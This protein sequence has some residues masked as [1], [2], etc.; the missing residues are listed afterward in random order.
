MWRSCEHL[1]ARAGQDVEAAGELVGRCRQRRQQPNHVLARARLEQQQAARA[2]QVHDLLRALGIGRRVVGPHD[3][4]RHH[5]AKAAHVADLRVRRR[6]ARCRASAVCAAWRVR[7]VEH[8]LVVEHV[9]HGERRRAGHGIAGVGAA[10]AAGRRRV[11]DGGLADHGRERQPAAQALGHRHEIRL[12]AVVL[13]GPHLPVR[14]K[15]RLDLVDDEHDAVRGRRCGAAHA[16]TRPAP[17]RSR[18]RRAAAR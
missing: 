3:L 14:P 2:R 17:A 11:H 9:E 18:P 7:L 13:V 12:D 15:P 6:H 16:G 1:A 8:L 5:R 4:D 10:Q